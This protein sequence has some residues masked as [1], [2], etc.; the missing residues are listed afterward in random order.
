MSL[1]KNILFVDVETTGLSNDDRVVSFGAVALDASTLGSGAWKTEETHLIFDP[2]V[3]SHPM[4]LKVHGYDDWTLRHQPP[5]PLYAHLVKSMISRCDLLVAHNA[6]FDLKFLSRELASARETWPDAKTYCTMQAE[7][8]RGRPAGLDAVCGRIGV[9][10]RGRRHSAFDDAFRAMQVF[11][12]Q[13]GVS[14]NGLASPTKKPSN[15][16]KVPRKPKDGIADRAPDVERAR[17]EKLAELLAL[18]RR[19]VYPGLLALRWIAG[20]AFLEDAKIA[21]VARAFMETE[22]AAH[23]AQVIDEFPEIAILD[24]ARLGCEWRD[25][26]NALDAI[27]SDLPKRQRLSDAIERCIRADGQIAKEEIE[28]LREIADYL[29]G[30]IAVAFVAT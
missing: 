6:D 15:L 29:G 14:V 2:G 11:L 5:F 26:R 1:P 17:I 30:Q 28:R 16:K 9:P 13:H 4:A 21:S 20:S 27:R 8:R 24:V 12:H 23:T 25:V 3:P 22:S 19:E 7:R 10:S 18:Q